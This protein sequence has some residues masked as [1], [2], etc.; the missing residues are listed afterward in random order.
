MTRT[1]LTAEDVV[2]LQS[3]IFDLFR[4]SPSWRKYIPVNPFGKPKWAHETKYYT[5]QEVP[6]GVWSIVEHNASP[7]LKPSTGYEATTQKY[8]QLVM[9]WQI[10]KN[11]LEISPNGRLKA[12]SILQIAKRMDKQIEL[13]MNSGVT[14]GTSIA[15][16]GLLNASGVNTGTAGKGSD[17]DTCY[18]KI[19]ELK[20]KLIEDA[21]NDKT[22]W[23]FIHDATIDGY[24]DLLHATHGLTAR[25]KLISNKIIFPERIVQTANVTPDTSDALA[26]IVESD[27]QNFHCRELSNGIEV[28]PFLDG[29]LDTDFM[30]K[31]FLEWV[32]TIVVPRPESVAVNSGIASA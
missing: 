19:K 15:V 20:N 4:E 2:D 16:T 13:A 23:F 3:D 5:M 12:D 24:L 28:H 29:A 32:G 31:G 21:F 17:M 18:T 11:D 26:A 8:L 10:H 22:K 25:E 14:V 7:D 30:F 27:P 9:A 6:N 1:R